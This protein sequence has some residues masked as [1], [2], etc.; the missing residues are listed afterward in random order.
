MGREV[1]KVPAN[2]VHP[3][4]QR[5]NHIP[6]F[7]R[8]YAKETAD[9]DEGERQWKAGFRSQTVWHDGGGYHEE[10]IP[11]EP[12]Y[13]EA[14]ICDDGRYRVMTYADWAGARP[15]MSDYMPDWPNELRTHLQMYETT[16][17]GTPISPV[18]DTPEAL[19]RWLA[20]NN[21]SAFANMTATYEQWLA[22]INRGFAPSAVIA[23]GPME[24]GVA[25]LADDA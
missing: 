6:L 2:W 8:S 13:H 24:S 22:T 9:W 18:M 19:A 21:A 1:R 14:R 4:D 10:W 11:K 23:H 17:E 16:S 25:A 15:A 3:R 12:E 7:G 5:G 20:D